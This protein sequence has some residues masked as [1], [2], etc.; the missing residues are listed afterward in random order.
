[1]V[2]VV[3]VGILDGMPDG[4]DV[5]VDKS[6]RFPSECRVPEVGIATAI[7]NS[8][9]TDDH[10]TI[11]GDIEASAVH[12]LD[13]AE[14]VVVRDVSLG[15]QPVVMVKQLGERTEVIVCG[16]LFRH[17]ATSIRMNDPLMHLLADPLFWCTT[18]KRIVNTHPVDGKE[19]LFAEFAVAEH[20]LVEVT[21]FNKKHATA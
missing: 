13:L 3:M 21:Y 11:F 8:R 4:H 15:F 19:M 9:T 18:M 17:N 20:F 7:N 12:L 2:V 10:F 16:Y 5:G 6:K 1:M 14:E